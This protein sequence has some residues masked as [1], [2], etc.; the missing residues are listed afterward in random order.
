LGLIWSAKEAYKKAMPGNQ[1]PGLAGIVIRRIRCLH[2]KG[3]QVEMAG[4]DGGRMEVCARPIC[5]GKYSL[6]LAP[7]YGVYY[8]ICRNCLR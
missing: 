6:A 5:R 3:W 2:K 8:K 1:P 4:P 7:A